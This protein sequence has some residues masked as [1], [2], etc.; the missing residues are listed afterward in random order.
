MAAQDVTD[1]EIN[2]NIIWSTNR[3][4]LGL[5]ETFPKYVANF[6]AKWNDWQQDISTKEFA[7]P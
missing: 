6:Q 5:L 3:L 2:E 1:F 7:L 4:Y